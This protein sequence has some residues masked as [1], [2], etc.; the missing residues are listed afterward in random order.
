MTIAFFF[1][2]PETQRTILENKLLTGLAIVP[3]KILF[4]RGKARQH[5]KN[6]STF[7]RGNKKS[8]AKQLNCNR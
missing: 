5:R 4:V 8:P 3:G 6:I 2:V 1:R 7:K